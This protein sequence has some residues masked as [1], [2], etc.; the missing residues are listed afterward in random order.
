MLTDELEYG[1][2]LRDAGSH[3][4]AYRHTRMHQRV[5][6]ARQKTV[7]DEEI[8]FDAELRVVPFEVA[9]A[10]AHNAVAQR[11]VLRPSG[12]SDRI[13]LHETELVNGFR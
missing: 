9:G 11:Q 13:R 2:R 1:L 12:R 6:C 3:P 4:F 10:V 7:V 5:M 8:F